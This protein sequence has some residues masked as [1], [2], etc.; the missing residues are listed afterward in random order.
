LLKI[1]NL[2]RH[3]CVFDWTQKLTLI[4]KVVW[5]GNHMVSFWWHWRMIDLRLLCIK[6]YDHGF[7]SASKPGILVAVFSY[8]PLYLVIWANS[9]ITIYLPLA[10]II[11]NFVNFISGTEWR[12]YQSVNTC[13]DFIRWNSQSIPLMDALGISL[14]FFEVGTVD[15]SIHFFFQQAIWFKKGKYVLCWY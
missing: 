2:L 8:F 1:P 13:T 11:I 10:Q 12:F 7:L 5:S 14:M 6:I 3:W 15:D 9:I 4:S